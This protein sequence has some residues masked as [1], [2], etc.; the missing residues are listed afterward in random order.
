MNELYENAKVWVLEA[1]ELIKDRMSQTLNVQIKTKHSDLVTTVDREV[2]SFLVNKIL[3][4]YPEHHVLG[5]ENVGNSKALSRN[6]W[7]IDPIDGTTNF[8][9]RKKDFAISV[10]FCSSDQ[11]GEVGVVYDVMR[12]KLYHAI[13]GSG[14]YL[15]ETKLS[16]LVQSSTLEEELV[17][18]NTDNLTDLRERGKVDRLTDRARGVRKYGATTIEM[19]EMAV[20][21]IGGYLQYLIKS[22]DY[23]ACRIILEE[24]GGKFSDWEGNDIGMLY[25]GC[26]VA[27]SP[28]VHRQMVETLNAGISG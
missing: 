21:R 6:V 2:E 10:A 20:G 19:C 5:E 24:L 22:W 18:M 28:N 7:V 15:N 26:L 11:Q 3:M 8:I 16:P 1:G 14:A 17:T 27:A 4:H 12:G 9:N 23:A 13:R 25:S